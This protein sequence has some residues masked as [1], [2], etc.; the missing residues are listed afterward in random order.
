[1]MLRLIAIVLSWLLSFATV[2]APWPLQVRLLTS[3]KKPFNF[4]QEQQVVGISV[5]L[6]QLMYAGMLPASPELMPWPR[7]YGTALQRKNTLLF[8]M[9]K[10]PERLAQGFQ[11]IGPVSR[12]VHYLYAISDKLPD[13][14]S[15]ADIKKQRLVVAG[16]RAGWLSE[17]F[18]AAGI[19]IETVGTYQQGIDML[20][21][22]HAQ[23]WLSTDLEQQV[24]QLRYPQTT[25]LVPV[26]RL[27]C[28]DNYI[29]ISPGSDPQWVDWLQQQFQQVMASKAA[30]DVL[31]K[32]Q[33]QLQLPLRLSPEFGFYLADS[34]LQQCQLSA[35]A[36]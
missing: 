9:G 34:A 18:K 28:S 16:L 22:N 25:R 27:L 29:G 26:W 32:W 4:Q 13:I 7:A 33:Q 31:K 5:D 3:E 19:P 30:T 23:L 21:R 6:L 36:G 1:M 15:L 10:T 14:R 35:E 17:Q 20:Q 11:F 24:L 8:T 2:A 12:R